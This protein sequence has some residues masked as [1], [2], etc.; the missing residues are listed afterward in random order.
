MFGSDH[1]LGS[2]G[3]LARR[4]VALA[5][6]AAGT[7]FCLPVLRRTAVRLF[8]C[9]VRLHCLW[10][11]PTYL[12]LLP[13]ELETRCSGGSSFCCSCCSDGFPCACLLR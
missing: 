1:L 13:W 12:L 3:A 9:A 4:G 5:K 2:N 7:C 8:R 11:K 10:L 6:A